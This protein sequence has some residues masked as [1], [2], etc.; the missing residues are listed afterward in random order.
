MPD[1]LAARRG[2]AGLDEPD[3]DLADREPFVGVPVEDL[4]DDGSLV[5]TDDKTRREPVRGGDL[6]VA[7]GDLARDDRAL[8]GTPELPATVALRDLGRLELGDRRLDLGHQPALGVVGGPALAKEHRDAKAAEL[9]EDDHLVDVVAGEPVRAED[10][11]RVDEPGRG[12]VA[13]AVE[14]G[15]VEAGA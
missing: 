15:P 10:D 3:S 5:F 7:E 14:P 11:H 6:A 8:A 1:L 12:C 9:V 13:G 4:P 2:Y